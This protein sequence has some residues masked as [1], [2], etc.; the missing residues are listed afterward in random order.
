MTW[1]SVHCRD[2][3]LC[4]VFFSGGLLLRCVVL[5]CVVM[6]CV[7]LCCSVLLCGVLCCV[8]WCIHNYTLVVCLMHVVMLYVIDV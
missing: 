4:C 8:M 3:V 7:V 2:V 6:V 1:C 5:C